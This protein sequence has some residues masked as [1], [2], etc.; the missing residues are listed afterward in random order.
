[1][2]RVTVEWNDDGGKADW[3]GEAAAM[4]EYLGRNGVSAHSVI[5]E[6]RGQYVVH[7]NGELGESF[8]AEILLENICGIARTKRMTKCVMRVFADRSPI[9]DRRPSIVQPN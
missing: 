3:N 7:F 9:F 4:R 5:L 6:K 8:L 2:N 1:M